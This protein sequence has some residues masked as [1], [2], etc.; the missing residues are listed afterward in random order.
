MNTSTRHPLRIDYRATVMALQAHER[1][2]W[3]LDL[4]DFLLPSPAKEQGTLGGKRLTPTE[5]RLLRLFAL[6][7]D[8]GVS[9]EALWGVLYGDLPESD[10]PEDK[11]VDVWLSRLRRPLR[12]EG[13]DLVRMAPGAWRIDC[14]PGWVWPWEGG[15]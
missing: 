7:G 12:A 8:R 2:D 10:W 1:V 11:I 9:R 6:A 5:L 15:A 14:P 3:L 13:L 4:L